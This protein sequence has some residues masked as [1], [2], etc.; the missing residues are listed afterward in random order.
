LTTKTH[1]AFFAVHGVASSPVTLPGLLRVMSET[2]S[3]VQVTSPENLTPNAD[4]RLLSTW[5]PSRTAL[6]IPTKLTFSSVEPL[7]CDL[8]AL[9]IEQIG[10]GAH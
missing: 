7:V 9:A 4:G 10:R 6:S 8:R 3:N 2:L 1:P 5:C